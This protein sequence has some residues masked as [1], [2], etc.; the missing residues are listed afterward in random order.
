MWRIAALLH[1]QIWNNRPA[2]SFVSTLQFLESAQTIIQSLWSE[3][4]RWS[5]ARLIKFNRRNKIVCCLIF[6][7]QLLAVSPTW[8]L[9]YGLTT[10]LQFSCQQFECTRIIAACCFH[11]SAYSC[12]FNTSICLT[13]LRTWLN[14]T[15]A[16]IVAHKSVM[17]EVQEITC[18]G[19]WSSTISPNM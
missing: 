14:I 9:M 7:N 19:D 6:L 8:T 17:T 13:H 11:K 2:C 15:K 1:S 10:R 4:S 16:V 18:N 5:G 3:F 12:I